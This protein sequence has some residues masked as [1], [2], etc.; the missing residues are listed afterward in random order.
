[1][2]N[3]IPSRC[4]WF[5][6]TKTKFLSKQELIDI[7]MKMFFTRTNT[8]FE[9]DNW[10]EDIPKED[11]QLIKQTF[12]SVT[13]PKEK[14]DGKYYAFYGSLGDV[15]NAYYHPTKSI[16]TN[17]YLN[18]S[19]TYTIG[20]DCVVIK[21]DLFYSGLYNIN[22]KY[23]QLMTECDIS[24]RKCLMNIR[25][26]NVVTSAD[27]TTDKSIKDFFDAVED[28]KFA[29]ITTKKFMDET[30]LQIHNV[31]SK[32]QNP[33][34]DLIEIKNFLDA[35]WWMDFGLNANANMKRETLTDAELNADD[36]TM[37]PLIKQM[38]DCEIKGWDEFN[39]MNGTSVKP[40][41]SDV[42]HKMYKDVI[43]PNKDE[44]NN[45]EPIED[46]PIDENKDGDK[47]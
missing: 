15:L 1:M 25:V 36:K 35:S 4:D 23:A 26:D 32:S 8:M 6:S 43:E 39:K 16:V 37:I 20:V 27:D 19:K 18:L 45:N 29:H 30:L 21:N 40:R 28:G 17:P 31:A 14:I 13:L 33:L 22:L 10:I 5:G 3:K 11:Y 2:E 44:T 38:L 12:G 42:W 47:E 7:Y 9:Y 46:K 34:K 24:I 41:L